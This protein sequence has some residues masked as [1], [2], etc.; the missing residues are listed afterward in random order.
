MY[1]GAWEGLWEGRGENPGRLGGWKTS[2]L[3]G[4]VGWS[5]CLSPL[6][7]G[8]RGTRLV[9]INTKGKANRQAGRPWVPKLAGALQGRG[10]ALEGQR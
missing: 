7:Q 6:G 1:R 9:G 10:E 3:V 2:S 4:A 8:R 5:S